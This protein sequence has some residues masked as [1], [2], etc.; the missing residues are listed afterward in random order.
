MLVT[1]LV[2]MSASRTAGVQAA[3]IVGVM[4]FTVIGAVADTVSPI[5]FA[6]VN[7]QVLVP[8]S[9]RFPVRFCTWPPVAM[10]PVP[11]FTPVQLYDS[12]TASVVLVLSA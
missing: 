12:E 1:K 10:V 11:A 4:I 6:A 5:E 8:T 9:D 3:V 2:A 7:T